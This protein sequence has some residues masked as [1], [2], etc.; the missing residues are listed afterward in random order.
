MRRFIRLILII[1]MSM[2]LFACSNTYKYKLDL[3]AHNNLNLSSSETPLPVVV[4]IYELT[5]LNKF[6]QAS[7]IKLWRNQNTA[8]GETLVSH[9]EITIQPGESLQLQLSNIK[10]DSKYLAIC[11]MFRIPEDKKWYKIVEIKNS[12]LIRTIKLKLNHNS[13][14]LAKK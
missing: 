6:E 10:K 5:E 9:R 14:E 1:V 13:I 12:S 2:Q 3:S 8:L 11:A 4:K 7:F